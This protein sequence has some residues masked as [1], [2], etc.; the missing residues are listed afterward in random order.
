LNLVEHT[1]FKHSSRKSWALLRKL[2]GNGKYNVNKEKKNQVNPNLVANRIVNLSRA[3]PDKQAT[4]NI[5]SKLRN[6]KIVSKERTA[7]S[8][9]FSIEKISEAILM[10]KSRKAA[11]LDNIYSEFIKHTGLRARA[12][13]L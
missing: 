9:S 6:L 10:I 11:G 4:K 1:D 3:T 8:A 12:W 13:L 2:G 5:K 7:Q